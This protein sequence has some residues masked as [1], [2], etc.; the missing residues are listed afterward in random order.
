MLKI[1]GILFVFGIVL[2]LLRLKIAAFAV[3]GIA[4]LVF[5]VLLILLAIESHQDKI[6][7]KLLEENER[8]GQSL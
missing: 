5:A 7:D 4:I 8:R 6:A 2:L 3:F 1:C